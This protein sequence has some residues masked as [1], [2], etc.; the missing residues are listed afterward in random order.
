M[1]LCLLQRPFE[2]RTVVK[3]LR[4]QS[5]RIPNCSS[6]SW[7]PTGIATS[8]DQMLKIGNL[9]AG[10]QHFRRVS[11]VHKFL[12][13]TPICRLHGSQH[14]AVQLIFHPQYDIP[15]RWTVMHVSRSVTICGSWLT[16][17]LQ[18]IQVRATRNEYVEY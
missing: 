9:N 2:G 3:L 7:Q 16:Y 1:F 12:A 14:V 11:L 5:P 4:F 17:F 15:W 10:C 6:R 8:G 18:R 13:S